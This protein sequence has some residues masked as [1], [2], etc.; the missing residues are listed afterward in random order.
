MS[1]FL[2]EKVLEFVDE[3]ILSNTLRSK[4]EGN[5]MDKIA[6]LYVLLPFVD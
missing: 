3:H 6:D 2:Q 4:L 5:N 1:L